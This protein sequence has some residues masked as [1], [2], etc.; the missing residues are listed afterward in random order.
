MSLNAVDRH[1]P[2]KAPSRENEIFLWKSGQKIDRI[3]SVWVTVFE[4]SQI[5]TQIKV[6][7]V[8]HKMKFHWPIK[9]AE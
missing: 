9:N 5:I 1:T 2:K 7:R 4:K 3:V 8:T 6:I